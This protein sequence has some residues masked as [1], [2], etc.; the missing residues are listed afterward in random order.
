MGGKQMEGDEQQRRKKARQAR[1][2][3][4][5][6]SEAGV[7]SGA[8]KQRRTLPRSDDYEEKI[9]SI[10]RGKQPVI[11]QN[12]PSKKPGRRGS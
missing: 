4:E 3:G 1:A 12:T 9:E 6:P 7:T 8:S 11:S 10:R 2:E 5:A